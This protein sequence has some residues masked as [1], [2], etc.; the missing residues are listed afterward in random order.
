MSEKL[1]QM[2]LVGFGPHNLDDILTWRETEKEQDLIFAP[3]KWA[4]RF[5]PEKSCSVRKFETFLEYV[6]WATTLLENI[7]KEKD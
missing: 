1:G 6:N 2:I 7:P 4:P 3:D 5:R